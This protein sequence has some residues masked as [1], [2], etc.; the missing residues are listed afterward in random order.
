MHVLCTSYNNAPVYSVTLVEAT[1]IGCMPVYLPPALFTESF[2]MLYR[3]NSGGGETETLAQKLTLDKN[4]LLPLG[5]GLK[6]TTFQ[7]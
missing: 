6:P 1:Y 2:Y 3:R 7:S 5:L 4:I